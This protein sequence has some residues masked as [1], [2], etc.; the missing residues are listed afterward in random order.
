M[1]EVKRYDV[2]GKFES[3]NGE[4]ILLVNPKMVLED[5]YDAK[6]HAAEVYFGSWKRTEGERDAA[7]SELAALRE[8]LANHDSAS[9]LMNAWIT[10]HKTQM[11]WDK[12]I[13]MI[14]VVTKMPVEEK[15]RLLCLDDQYELVSKRLADAERRNAELTDLIEKAHT[16]VDRN[17]C[18]GWDAYEL[19]DRLA[20][21][22]KPTESGA[23]E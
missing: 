16:W 6:C 21:A 11:P 3:Q 23:S 14:A 5:D 1:S 18:G 19:R 10:E 8:E 20:D 2:Q 15:Q 7:K 12:A 22:L 17:N 13:E 4:G 9:L